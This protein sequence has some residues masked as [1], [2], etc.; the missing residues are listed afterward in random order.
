MN[1][2]YAAD[3]NYAY[4][5][6][7]SIES[8]YINNST[9]KE[10][11]V[12]ILDDGISSKNKDT[13]NLIADKYNRIINYIDVAGFIGEISNITTVS[14]GLDQK[15]SYTA[16]ARFF[17]D[18]LLPS[19]DKVIYLD[20]DTLV[21]GKLSELFN[22]NMS[23]NAV[24]AMVADC[25]HHEYIKTLGISGDSTYFNTG[26]MLLDIKRWRDLKCTDMILKHMKEVRSNYPLVDQDIINVVLGDK[27]DKVHLKYNLQTPNFMYHKYKT[28]CRVYGLCASNYYDKDEHNEA[29]K[30]PVVIHFSGTSFVRPWYS[31]SNHPMKKIYMEYYLNNPF[32]DEIEYEKRRFK[33]TDSVKIRYLMYKYLPQ[34]INGVI[35][36]Y[37]MKRWIRKAYIGKNAI[38]YRDNNINVE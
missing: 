28:V 24:I 27:I 21:V 32:F 12:Y 33:V 25:T 37:C 38:W 20:C 15:V 23:K 9:E 11:N 30:K 8:L 34:G 31:N 29:M 4:L 3:D 6:G 1:I 13:L 16:Y 22:Y 18:K 10:I 7:I 19:L 2:V 26:V 35:S 17:I 14:Y 36:G 5:A